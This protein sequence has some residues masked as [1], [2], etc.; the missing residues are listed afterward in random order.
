MFWIFTVAIIVMCI[1]CACLGSE[2]PLDNV[3]SNK[4][5]NLEYKGFPLEEDLED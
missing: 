5:E 1:M 4:M 2:M 3:R